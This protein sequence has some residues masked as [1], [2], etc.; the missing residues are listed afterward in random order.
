MKKEDRHRLRLEYTADA[1]VESDHRGSLCGTVRDVGMDSIYIYM[2]LFFE[3]EEEVRLHITIYGKESRL[4]I[5]ANAVVVRVDQ[6]GLAL[7]FTKPLEWWP[8]FSFY[9]FRQ[10]A[11]EE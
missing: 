5:T 2:D 7:Q 11:D 3:L 10:L 6:D 4:S 1:V 8:I 9:P